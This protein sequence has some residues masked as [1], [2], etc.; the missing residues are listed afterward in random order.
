MVRDGL[1]EADVRRRMDAQL[2]IGQKVERADYV[3][4]TDGTFEDTDRQ[5]DE[6]AAR[7]NEGRKPK[8]QSPKPK[9]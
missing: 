7:L 6:V 2:P 1:S 4:R 5:V 8:A 9:V 3:I